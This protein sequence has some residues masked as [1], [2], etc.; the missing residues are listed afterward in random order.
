M[1]C[2]ARPS[3]WNIFLL[4]VLRETMS[5]VTTEVLAHNRDYLQKKKAHSL[6]AIARVLHCLRDYS[7]R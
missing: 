5:S 6:L 3:D 4:L 2:G 1:A 7:S